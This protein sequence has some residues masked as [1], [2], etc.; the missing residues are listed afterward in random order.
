[1]PFKQISVFIWSFSG[2][3]LNKRNLLAPP[4]EGVLKGAKKS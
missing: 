1:M 4:L 2:R 3:G